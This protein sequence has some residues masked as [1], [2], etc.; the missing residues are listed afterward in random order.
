M[1]A[2]K[3]SKLEKMLGVKLNSPNKSYKHVIEWEI[4]ENIYG[5]LL[6]QGTETFKSKEADST[7]KVLAIHEKLKKKYKVNDG[8]ISMRIHRVD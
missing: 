7:K 5:K 4:R 3:Y 1:T 2:K 6:H 8:E